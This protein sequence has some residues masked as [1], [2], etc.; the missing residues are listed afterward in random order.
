MVVACTGFFDG[1]HL[2]H[3]AV[4]ERVCTLAKEHG[5]KSLVITFWPHPRAVLQQDAVN[6]RLITSLEEKIEMLTS[7][8]IDSVEVIPFTKDFARLT[9]KEFFQDY[10]LKKY[11][12]NHFV[13]GYDH[14]VGSDKTQS[15]QEMLDIAELMGIKTHR[16]GEFH[17]DINN[18]DIIISSTKIRERISSGD[19]NI[20]NTLLGYNYTLSGV[21]VSGQK[22]GRKL[23]FPTANIK[24]YEP[25]KLLPKDGVYAVKVNYNGH[26]YNGITNIGTR[27]TVS[28]GVQKSI[29]TH[30]LDFNEQ[31]YGLTISVEFIQRIRE[32][33]KFNSIDELIEQLTK[34]REYAHN[35]LS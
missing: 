12:V 1:I 13:V 33:Q 28:L 35:L 15:Q 3:R 20:A 22:L 30:I 31:I 14:R 27:P 29:E 11:G 19:V 5:C 2:G 18:N 7:I 8:G 4:I 17:K 24:L 26:Q 16:V 23:G 32:E 21:V 10:L 25:L 6:F 9:T 34:D